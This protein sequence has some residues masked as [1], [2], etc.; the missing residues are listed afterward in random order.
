MKSKTNIK[1]ILTQR[2]SVTKEDIISRSY[3]LKNLIETVEDCI[4]SFETSDSTPRLPD[5][6]L[7]AVSIGRLIEVTH[8]LIV[9]D[10]SNKDW[11]KASKYIETLQ[12]R[13]TNVLGHYQFLPIGM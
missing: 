4:F 11:A 5:I 13:L 9:N 3:T 1:N 10:N 8:W 7:T 2:F 12:L 6:V